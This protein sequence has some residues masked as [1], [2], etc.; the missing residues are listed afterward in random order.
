VRL[1][2][3]SAAT[4]MMSLRSIARSILRAV[5]GFYVKKAEALAV[6]AALLAPERSGELGARLAEAG[7]EGVHR[8]FAVRFDE[9]A[10][11]K[12]SA[13]TSAGIRVVIDAAEA[14]AIE[15]AAA[16]WRLVAEERR[17]VGPPRVAVEEQDPENR[18][19]LRPIVDAASHVVGVIGFLVDE[20]YFREIYLPKL[21]AEQSA[22][23]P[24]PL[25]GNVLVSVLDP[26]GR[27]L[28]G[29]THGAT[30]GA[31][32]SPRFRF[33]FGDWTLAVETRTPGPQE[34]AR[35]SFAINLALALLASGALAVAVWLALRSAAR[36]TR[37]SRM[38]TDFVSNVSHELRTP[39]ASIRVFG[40]FLRLGRAREPQQIQRYGEA[41]EAE[42]ERLGRL[43]DNILDVSQIESGQKRYQREKTDLAELVAETV[44]A[45]DMRL[46]GAGFALDFR[47][48][49][50]PLPPISADPAAVAQAITNLL[51]N[52]LKYS[53]D[54][55]TIGVELSRANGSVSVS[56]TDRGIG[57]P[58]EERDRIFEKFYRVTNGLVRDVEGSGLGLAIVKDVVEAHGGRIVVESRPGGGSTFTIVLPADG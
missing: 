50:S 37:L 12:T 13:F 27:T 9:A 48:P 15:F 6:P 21:V 10:A 58:A 39:L 23:I 3:T 14:A 53:G 47:P 20:D 19:V 2:E 18:V 24:E 43:V 4:H 45:F 44:A 56:V 31:E 28:A 7:G 57:I 52:A 1:Q 54:S 16:P 5:E 35:W 40:E 30:L 22:E 32:I 46:R 8:F 42:C 36:A 29:S 33:L 11:P 17:S 55:R 41:I 26:S 25:R 38:K 49:Q 51:D 34:W